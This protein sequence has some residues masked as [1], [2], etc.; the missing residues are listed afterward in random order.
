[1]EKAPSWLAPKRVGT[2]AKHYECWEGKRKVFEKKKEA[3]TG[4]NGSY[5]GRLQSAGWI[6]IIVTETKKEEKK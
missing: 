1:M 6:T 4:I 5:I 3:G 2:T